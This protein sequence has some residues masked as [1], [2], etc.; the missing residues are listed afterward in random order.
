MCLQ[1]TD[2]CFK[3]LFMYEN[4]HCIF[5]RKLWCYV[6]TAPPPPTPTPLQY[7]WWEGEGSFLCVIEPRWNKMKKRKSL[8]KL[9]R[10]SPLITSP[11][12]SDASREYIHP[13]PPL[14]VCIWRH[15][16]SPRCLQCSFGIVSRRNETQ[17]C[18]TYAS[19]FRKFFDCTFEIR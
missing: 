1:I 19:I 11:A 9:R 8:W 18:Y 5:E 14:Y 17:T 12:D 10:A 7:P 3:K 6:P 15:I 16:V 4:L 13:D 2:E